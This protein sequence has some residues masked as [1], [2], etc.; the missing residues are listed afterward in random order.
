M[1]INWTL[2]LSL[3]I[4]VV[5]C[6][7]K[8]KTSS[9]SRTEE[10]VTST[11]EVEKDTILPSQQKM[12]EINEM[13]EGLSPVRSLRWEKISENGQQSFTSVSAYLNDDGIPVKIIE[14]YDNGN[15][16]NQGERTFYLENNEIIAFEENRDVWI[17]STDFLYEEIRSFYDN[18]EPVKNE[19]RSAS[20]VSEI[21][22]K[23]WNR[24]RPEKHSLTKIE[25]ILSGKGR[26]ATHFISVIDISSG[27]FLLLGEA[28]NEDRYQTAV[29]VDKKT[30]FIED[31]LNNLDKYK[32][33]P[34]DIQFTIEG[35]AGQPQFQ[36]LT[37]ARWK[38]DK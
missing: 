17:D 25:N 31:L 18:K 36:V 29:R 21:E 1:K 15:Y 35:G 4:I 38:G 24:I 34:I 37:N 2:I 11:N 5:S 19:K 10:K 32:F 13:I 20:S 33:K 28:K 22:N 14:E 7:Q 9:E 12:D 26:F 23:K 6:Q 27:L 8:T 30:P 16:Q 3:F